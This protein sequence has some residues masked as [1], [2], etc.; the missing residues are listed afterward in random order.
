M[1][2]DTSS[3]TQAVLRLEKAISCVRDGEDSKIS[4]R[5]L[6]SYVVAHPAYAAGGIWS[7]KAFMKAPYNGLS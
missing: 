1:T 5:Y 2:S 7:G 6:K 4:L 3:Q